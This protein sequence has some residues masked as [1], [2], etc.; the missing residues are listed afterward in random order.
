MR[1]ALAGRAALMKPG[2]SMPL[3]SPMCRLVAPTQC[4][5]RCRYW[6]CLPPSNSVERFGADSP[7]L[8]QARPEALQKNFCRVRPAAGAGNGDRPLA[9]GGALPQAKPERRAAPGGGG[10][11]VAAA[12]LHLR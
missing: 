4:Q 1:T 5:A 9:G 7:S 3:Q 8:L 2:V 12:E 6:D 11:P 10:G